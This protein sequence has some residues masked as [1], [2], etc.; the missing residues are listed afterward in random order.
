[1]EI[2][3][4]MAKMG[5][6]MLPTPTPNE[7]G[8]G[9]EKTDVEQMNKQGTANLNQANEQMMHSTSGLPGLVRGS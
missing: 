5:Q 4:R 2:T 1:M 6:A 3:S 7:G 8:G 9:Q